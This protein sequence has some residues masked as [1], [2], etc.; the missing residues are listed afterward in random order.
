MEPVEEVEYLALLFGINDY[1]G[2]GSDLRG[3]INDINDV[4]T[5]LKREFPRFVIR[6]FTDS[7]VTTTLMVKEIEEALAKTQK[8]LYIHYSGHGTTIGTQEALYLYNGPLMDSVFCDLQNKTPDY[9]HVIAKFDS[10][11]SGGM[12]DRKNNP[13]YIRSRYFPIPGMKAQRKAIT[14]VGRAD[15]QKWVIF[16]GCGESQTSADAFFSGRANGA[17]TFFDLRSFISSSTY[18]KEYNKL[19]TYL[20]DMDFDQIPELTGNAQLF[21]IPV[22][23]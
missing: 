11:Y 18:T 7:Q 23:S 6:K 3:C 21:D 4:E 19:R 14:H 1:Q 8:V 16:S 5:K 10:C 9:L 20:P 15:V 13:R 17:F 12:D 22:L 2:T